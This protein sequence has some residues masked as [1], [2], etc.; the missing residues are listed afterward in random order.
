MGATK[1]PEVS[2]VDVPP[3]RPS[4]RSLLS[5]TVL[6]P[7]LEQTSRTANKIREELGLEAHR[8]VLVRADG[9][10]PDE[11]VENVRVAVLRAMKRTHDDPGRI[12]VREKATRRLLCWADGGALYALDQRGEVSADDV[13]HAERRLLASL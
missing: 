3:E 6:E 13:V 11:I 5:S 2:Y 1:D 9:S 12:E 7:G 10:R 8:Y 4:E